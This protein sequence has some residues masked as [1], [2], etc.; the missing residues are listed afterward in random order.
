MQG[1]QQYKHCSGIP[2]TH[3]N[4]WYVLVDNLIGGGDT[5]DDGP[6]TRELALLMV[7]QG[8]VGFSRV[9]DRKRHIVF[10]GEEE[11]FSVISW[12]TQLIGW[13]IDVHITSQDGHLWLYKYW[14]PISKK[15][16][17]TCGLLAIQLMQYSMCKTAVHLGLMT[18][19]PSLM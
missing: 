11:V 13:K 9:D 2:T 6:D 3:E 10:E 12:M 1:V 19:S 16:N 14:H 7:V 5:L 15:C 17:G 18:Q 4:M 8:V